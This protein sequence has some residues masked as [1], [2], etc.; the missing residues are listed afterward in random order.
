M[1][2]YKTKLFLLTKERKV[3]LPQCRIFLA[4]SCVAYRGYR[5]RKNRPKGS[6]SA[7]ILPTFWRCHTSCK[8]DNTT[9]TACSWGRW[10]IRIPCPAIHSVPR[11]S[12]LKS[13]TALLGGNQTLLAVRC[14]CRLWS[15]SIVMP[16]IHTKA[17]EHTFYRVPQV[18]FD[19]NCVFPLQR[20]IK[21]LLKQPVLKGS[22]AYVYMTYERPKSFPF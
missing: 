13:G 9:R 21:N 12:C 11:P 16:T 1:S 5:V 10:S 19:R 15:V 14:C 2:P 3:K 6:T 8:V 7:L 4:W 22:L 18:L 20:Q 17:I